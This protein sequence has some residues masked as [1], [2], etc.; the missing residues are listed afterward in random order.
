[1]HKVFKNYPCQVSLLFVCTLCMNLTNK[2]VYC[3]LIFTCLITILNSMA[4]CHGS[5]KSMVSIVLSSIMA[6]G[7]L[8][9]K[10]YMIGGKP[11]N[12]LIIASLSSILIA[13]YM[14]HKLFLKLTAKYSFSLSNLISLWMAGL[15]DHLI[16]GI[17]FINIFPM[18]KVWLIF[19]KETGYTM[20]FGSVVY[21]CLVGA[22][23]AKRFYTRMSN[24][25]IRE[26]LSGQVQ[27]K[28]PSL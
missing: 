15:V 28:A 5:K 21:L 19:C 16:M 14:G 12:G 20:L 1:M 13:S 27:S 23:Y 11:I 22:T 3:A 25:C 2:I 17:Y 8:Y 18:H 7:L 10:P 9:N 24:R 4:K 6:C 26:P